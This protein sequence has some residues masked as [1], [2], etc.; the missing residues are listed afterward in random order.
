MAI[1]LA[2]PPPV[3]CSYQPPLTHRINYHSPQSNPKPKLEDVSFT[4]TQKTNTTHHHPPW[5]QEINKLCQSGNLPKALNLLN[6]SSD[7]QDFS[8]YH[9][10]REAIGVLLQA[11]GYWKDMETGGK[12][13]ELVSASTRFRN[14]IVLNTRLVTMYSMC[15]SPLDS[16]LV[17]DRLQEKNLFVWNALVSAYTRN[18]LFD[19]SINLFV[20]LISETDFKPDYF[21]FPCMFKAC[22]SIFDVGLGQVFH[23]MAIKVGLVMDVFVGNALVGMYGKC[24]CLED[25]VRVFEKIPKR[26]LVSWNSMIRGFSNN[27]LSYECYNLL[28]EILGEGFLP[29]DA[30]IVTLLPVCASEGNVDM[31]MVIHGLAVKLGLNEEMMVKNA[32]MDMYSKCGYLSEAMI[33]FDKNNKKNVVSWNSIIGGFSREGDIYGTFDLLQR[34]QVED[35]NVRPNEITILNV[36]PA[37]LEEKELES[38]KEIHGYSVRHGFHD[39]EMVANAFIAAYT[40]CGCLDYAQ[41]MFYGIQNKTVSSWNALIGGFAQNGSPKPALDFYFKMKN[42]GLDPDWFTIGSLILACAHLKFMHYAKQIHGFVLRNGLDCDSFIG[43]SLMSIYI[44]CNKILYAHALFSRMEDKDLVCWNT[45]LTGYTQLELPGEALHLFRQMLSN[46]VRPYEIAVTSAFEACSQLLA[47]RLGKEL[48]CFALKAN[49]MED[50]FV[51]CSI[52][53]MYAKN[54]CMEQAQMVFDSLSE[55]DVASWNV[56]IAGYGINGHGSKALELF[57]EMYRLWLKPDRFTFI[58]VLMACSHAGMVKEGIQYFNEMQDLYGIEP[59]LEHYACVVDMLGRAGRIEEALKLTSE[60][61]EEADARI[62]SSLLSSC[63][64]HGNLEMGTKIAQRLLELE[65]EKAENYVLVSNLYAGSRKWDDAR[66]VRQRM[67]KIGLQKDAGRSWIEL[68]GKVYSFFAGDDMLPSSMEIRDMWKNLEEK[69][70]L[71]GYVP[72]TSCVLH[73]LEEEEKIEK[74]RGHSEKL[75]ISFGLLKTSKGSTI[76]VCKNLRIC[77][78]CH[79][80]A[81]LI[82]KAFEREIVVRDNKRFHHFKDGLCSC[83]DYW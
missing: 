50:M 18:Q 9:S 60:M 37:C 72:N 24:G 81:K 35:E 74:L 73:E 11:C 79:N 68:G 63:R 7:S 48:H 76:R 56:L 4:F 34:M 26:N 78:D 53:D 54:G 15:G 57:E 8:G 2:P 69:I 83:S 55:R 39:D 28:R 31:G 16:R 70:T 49:L 59:K 66:R 12:I 33:L 23:G 71:I 5:F 17:F 40:K 21:T 14:D 80:A 64:I 44:Q 82:S 25:A 41:H 46:G 22:S 43:I 3:S 51:G 52:L 62:W 36:L 47:L 6:K 75:A 27:G 10:R 20:E 65:P 61:P 42:A 30:T 32:L 77:L 13:H 58:G 29:D 67:K 1:L 38:L 45:M 19:D